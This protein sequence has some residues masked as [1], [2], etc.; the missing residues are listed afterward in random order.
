MNG[1]GPADDEEAVISLFDDF[2]GIF[3][4]LTD[5]SEGDLGLWTLEELCGE[6]GDD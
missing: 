3:S 4:T 2:N 1:A 6:E 5:C